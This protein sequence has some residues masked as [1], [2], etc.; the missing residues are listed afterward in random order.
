MWLGW[1][2]RHPAKQKVM[3]LIPSQG[4]CLRCKFGPWSGRVR[5]ATN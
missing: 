5:E 4:T 3:G 1:S 2:E